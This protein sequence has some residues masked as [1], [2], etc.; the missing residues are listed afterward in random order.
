MTFG[1]KRKRYF[2]GATRFVTLTLRT[3]KTKAF[4]CILRLLK[5]PNTRFFVF[6]FFHLL[7]KSATESA[8]L[9]QNSICFWQETILKIAQL[10]IGGTLLVS[11][12]KTALAS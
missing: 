7:G 4:V 11:H 8:F 5:F 10:F 9:Q 2:R 6:R 3:D 1:R 12:L